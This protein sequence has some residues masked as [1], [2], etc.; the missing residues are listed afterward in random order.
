VFASPPANN[1]MFTLRNVGSV[2]LTISGISIT[3]ADAGAFS[4]GTPSSTNIAANGTAT[5][6]VGLISDVVG[7]HAATLRLTSNDPQA[8]PLLVP[9]SY[10]I[11]IRNPLADDDHDGISN[12]MEYAFGLDPAANSAGQLPQFIATSEGH[13]I[14]FTQPA[15]VTG[16]IYGVEWSSTMI[17]GSWEAVPDTVSGPNHLFR[18]PSAGYPAAFMRLKVTR[19]SNP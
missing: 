10:N 13:S 6:T 15:A 5:F 1:V 11:E 18:I 9:L 8:N 19:Q 7:A 2:A 14:S 4:V 12:L 17:L 16:I 3:G